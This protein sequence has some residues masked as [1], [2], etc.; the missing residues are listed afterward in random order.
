MKIIGY[1]ICGPGESSRYMRETLEEF[2]RLCDEVI[3]LCN[4]VNQAEIDLIK[5]YGFKYRLDRREWGRF[6]WRIKQDFIE[7]DIKQMAQEGDMLVCLDMDEVFDK[8]LT[9]EWIRQ[10]PLDAYYVFI[11]DLWNDPEHYKPESCFWNVRMWRWNGETKFH[12]KPVHCGLAP[13][14]AYKYHRHAPFILKHYGL[15]LKEDRERKIKR[16]EKYDP[17]AEY[18][19]RKFYKMLSDDTAKPFNEEE[20]HNTISK[21]VA[22]Y[23]QSKPRTMPEK[24]K[25][26]RFAYVKNPHGVVVDIPERH[27]NE[28]LKRQG[29]EMVGWA[30]EA[31]EE[32]EELFAEDSL[33]EN[34]NP[35]SDEVLL[36]GAEGSYQTSTAIQK[37]QYESMEERDSAMIANGQ[38][39]SED[40]SILD[41]ED[42]E[43]LS[44]D[45]PESED[46]SSEAQEEIE[47][48]TKVEKEAKPKS[49]PK[50]VTKAKPQAQ[51]N[52]K[53]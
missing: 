50:S 47:E 15:M 49:K 39:L 11:V 35:E 10:A 45:S 34:A 13:E 1:G 30:D 7:R 29:F 20:I 4:N 46:E 44:K 16:Y 9:K 23:Q 17:K 21:E 19:D 37:R 48:N 43:F 22:T 41:E 52:K 2:K 36:D 38:A 24:K 12:A 51:K 26:E 5:E 33:D 8:N 40:T 31:Q 42:L 53:K 18:L 6:Q 25:K 14:W 32:I 3:I 27:V 28:T